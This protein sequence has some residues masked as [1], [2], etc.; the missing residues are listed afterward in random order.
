ML[1]RPP[2]G[3]TRAPEGLP[4]AEHHPPAQVGT[5]FTEEPGCGLAAVGGLT[6]A[7][8][9]LTLPCP[10]PPLCQSPPRPPPCCFLPS[11]GCSVPIRPCRSTLP[12][13]QRGPFCHQEHRGSGLSPWKTRPQRPWPRQRNAWLHSSPMSMVLVLRIQ[14]VVRKQSLWAVKSSQSRAHPGIPAL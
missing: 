1:P 14:R 2:W 10:I 5:C 3:V 8:G 12:D 4:L 6:P 9:H 11:W 7:W 13:A